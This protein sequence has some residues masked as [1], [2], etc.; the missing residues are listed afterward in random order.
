[1]LNTT[2][3]ILFSLFT[4]YI[5]IESVSYSIFEINEQKNKFGG[6]CLLIFNLF[7]FILSNIIV[8]LN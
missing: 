1:M 8:W 3:K 2:Y 4:I 7:C 6:T 5:F